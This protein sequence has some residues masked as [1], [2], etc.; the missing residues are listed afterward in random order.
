[1]GNKESMMSDI[2][3]KALDVPDF[4]SDLADLDPSKKKHEKG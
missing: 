4:E 2:Q 3:T 1:M